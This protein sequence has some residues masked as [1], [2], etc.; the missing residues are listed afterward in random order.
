MGVQRQL[1]VDR[2]AR[3]PTYRTK[4]EEYVEEN[5]AKPLG[6]TSFAWHLSRKTAIA[7]NI[8]NMSTR[9]ED[10]TFIDGPMP[11]WESGSL[12]AGGGAGIYAIV[13]YVFSSTF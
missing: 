13:T 2:L 9:Q 12:A 10:G 3:C 1:R 11:I 5:F 4:S 8:L 6:I 7:Q